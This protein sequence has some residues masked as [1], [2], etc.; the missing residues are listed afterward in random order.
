MDDIRIEYHLVGNH[1][2][3]GRLA[4][5]AVVAD[6]IGAFYG[7]NYLK[8]FDYQNPDHSATTPGEMTNDARSLGYVHVRVCIGINGSGSANPSVGWIWSKSNGGNGGNIYIYNNI[9]YVVNG[10]N[11]VDILSYSIPTTW[12]NDVIREI[13]WAYDYNFFGT[14]QY[15]SVD[16]VIVDQDSD[17]NRKVPFVGTAGEQHFLNLPPSGDIGDAVPIAA[18]VNPSN[19]VA[20]RCDVWKDINI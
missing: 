11:S 2:D 3:I 9:L 19:I 18:Q 1:I 16:G 13:I 20:R 10:D 4:D 15:L 5:I 12:T 17:V 6:N 7:E 8:K 14:S